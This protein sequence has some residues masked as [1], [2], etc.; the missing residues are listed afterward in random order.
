M[1]EIRDVGDMN[2]LESHIVLHRGRERENE[3][4]LELLGVVVGG[5]GLGGRRIW[6]GDLY[7]IQENW[8]G[9]CYSLH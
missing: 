8:N 5:G 6:R 9:R 7:N 1:I 3:K 4:E 2:C